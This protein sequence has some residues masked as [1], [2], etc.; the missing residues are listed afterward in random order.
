M[1]KFSVALIA[2]MMLVLL[3]LVVPVSANTKFVG[4]VI[5]Q[6]ATVFIGEQGLNV[7]NAMQQ[8]N[9][10]E[11]NNPHPD[12]ATVTD[13]TI[14]WWASGAT[15]TTTAPSKT[16]QLSGRMST[17]EVSPSDF[18]GYL[19]NW[20]LINNLNGGAAT[21]NQVV[22]GSPIAVFTVADPQLD[23]SIYNEANSNS[24]N[25]QT[26]V[27]GTNLTFQISTAL[28]QI[29]NGNRVDYVSPA[30]ATVTQPS[31]NFT[32]TG[33]GATVYFYDASNNTPT[34]YLWTFTDPAATSTSKNPFHTYSGD[35]TYTVTEKATN[36]AGTSTATAS[37]TVSSNAV[38]VN[39]ISTTGFTGATNAGTLGTYISLPTTG[40]YSTKDGFIDIKVKNNAD[41]TYTGLYNVSGSSNHLNDQ[42][43]NTQP[44]Y[45]S[46]ANGNTAYWYTKSATSGQYDYPVG[47]YTITAESTLNGMKDNYRI[48]GADF[49]GKTVSTAYTIS[50]QSDVVKLTQN[51]DSVIRGKPFSIT[52]TGAADSYYDLWVSGTSTMPAL[53]NDSDTLPPQISANQVGVDVGYP[54]TGSDQYQTGSNSIWNDT[55]SMSLSMFSPYYARVKTDDSG[56]RTVEFT[57]GDQTKAQKYTIKTQ[58][59]S[60]ITKHD[61]IDIKIEKGSVSVVA[62]GDQSYYLG[63]DI[64]LSGT[65]SESYTT[66]LY[67]IG[68]NLPSIGADLQNPNPRT[69]GVTNGV[70]ST[71]TTTPVNGDNTWTYEWGTATVALDAGTYT[72]FAVDRP[73]D[74]DHL[75]NATYGTVSVI[76]KKPF[77]SASISQSTVA[78]GDGFHITGTAEGDPSQG[79]AI[80]ILGKNYGT[81]VTQS[82]NSDSSFDY[83][84]KSASTTNLATGQYFVVIQHPM[85]NNQFD[86]DM[87]DGYS[88]QNKQLLE[89][90]H[91]TR[92]FTLYGAGSLQGSDA[93]Q[94]LVEAISSP[95]IDD[96][97]TKLQYLIETPLIR[98]DEI[99]DK[100]VGDKFTVTATTN[101]AV[102]DQIQVE[103]YS[104]SFKPT[105]KTQS[106]EFSGATGT[107]MVTKGT[108]NTGFNSI[109]FPVDSSAFKSDE[110]IVTESGIIQDATGTALFNVLDTAAPSVTA[111]AKVVTTPVPTAVPT[112]A[113][114]AVPT[115]VVV[116]TT[117]AK[118]PGFGA[119]IALIGLGAIAFIIVRRE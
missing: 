98:I 44:Y 57:T 51:K 79:V 7:T 19:G 97:Y 50:L 67:L 49:T 74:N 4:T 102:G 46:D 12:T 13:T 73:Y 80:W 70:G 69:A 89:N 116:T 114:T 62:A 41:A 40:G 109:T 63:E 22:G 31:A 112:P 77:V 111:P 10:K 81:R 91:P 61:S 60:D 8:A 86:I 18:S 90:G 93:A 95:N 1:S 47:T 5:N 55:P 94:A 66:Y 23:L 43:V 78:Q 35:G 106:G 32:V 99:G 37:I 11:Y 34:N 38:I 53:G 101:L 96:T 85:Q 33:T 30:T 75:A 3:I 24:V 117:T 20:Y 119:L 76:L 71:F 83:E 29:A 48:G 27:Q 15:I 36:A 17:F 26:V 72:I 9:A 56:V 58:S 92:I 107:V 45:W 103:I 68:P 64:K 82:V 25:G 59:Q 21:V 54:V 6:S 14:G 84:V 104:S 110:Y 118:S 16:I 28:S 52:I 100:H 65:N 115:A 108:G 87:A 42:Y 88:V 113:P 39:S 105:Q 2:M